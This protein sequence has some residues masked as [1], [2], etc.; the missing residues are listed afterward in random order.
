[1][2]APTLGQAVDGLAAEPEHLARGSGAS[3]AGQAGRRALLAAAAG[4]L[5]VATI[6][7][8][9][10]VVV[11][12]MHTNR[13]LTR[14]PLD[15]WHYVTASGNGAARHELVAASLTTAR[16]AAVGLLAGTAAALVAAVGFSFSRTAERAVMPIA[17]AFRSVPL[18]AMTPLIVLIF[19]RGLAAVAV[20]AGI[21]T[22]FPVLVNVSLALR[23]VPAPSIDLMHAYGASPTET[24][25]RVQM[26]AALPALFAAIRISAPLALVG[27]LLAEWLATGQGLGYFMLQSQFSS[28]YD[29]MWT[30][31]AV[32]T[33]AAVVLYAA[34]SA[35]EQLVLGRFGEPR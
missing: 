13:F 15:V 32:T 2:T 6:L 29:K 22:F 8:L 5:S 17:M 20:L 25:W 7:V 24:L 4:L 19:D 21:V 16:D 35:T 31:V 26:P 34:V 11:E 12:G 33:L 30:G 9:W 14:G 23:A 3:T 1:M 27:A 28:D 10:Q 18:V